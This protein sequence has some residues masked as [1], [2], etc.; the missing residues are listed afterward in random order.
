VLGAAGGLDGAGVAAAAGALAGSGGGGDEDEPFSE[1]HQRLTRLPLLAL[2]PPVSAL[3]VV[4]H[5][6]EAPAVRVGFAAEVAEE[7]CASGETEVEK[8]AIEAA[9]AGVPPPS[10]M[11]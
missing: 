4:V 11:S 10:A 1:P 7:P 6:P 2:A 5:C 3:A 8:A 9:S